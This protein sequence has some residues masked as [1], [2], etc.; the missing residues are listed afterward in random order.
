MY[1]KRNSILTDFKFCTM[2][3]FNIATVE[4]HDNGK[5]PFPREILA[6]EEL[7]GVITLSVPHVEISSQPLFLFFTVDITGSMS[8]PG[9]RG[10][11]KKIDYVIQT[12]KNMFTYLFKLSISVR[13]CVNTFNESVNVLIP[14]TELSDPGVLAELLR[15]VENIE[16]SGST[17]IEVALKRGR[18]L[19]VSYAE[20][21]RDHQLCHLFMT[22][23]EA[24]DGDRNPERLSSLVDPQF[25]MICVG[26][27]LKH[28]VE[29]LR[30]LGSHPNAEYQF[31]DNMENTTLVYGESIHQF[32]YPALRSIKIEIHGG[33]IYHW[34]TDTWVDALEE[35]LF[36]GETTKK[37]H[38]RCI[39]P[40]HLR[41]SISA[42]QVSSGELRTIELAVGEIDGIDLTRYM[43]RQRVQEILAS[44]QTDDNVVR[45]LVSKKEIRLVFRSLREYMREKE[46]TQDPFLKTLCDDLFVMY[47]TMDQKYGL[48]YSV[49]RQ[50]SQGRQQTYNIS[51]PT[52][53]DFSAAPTFSR[54]MLR[55]TQTGPQYA[56]TE[57]IDNMEAF[58]K[59]TNDVNLSL[60][61]PDTL[62]DLE[63]TLLEIS[64]KKPFLKSEDDIE[65]YNTNSAEKFTCYATPSIVNTVKSMETSL[66]T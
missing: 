29:L 22:D 8:E 37:Y 43:Y 7:F 34:K 60:I 42:V 21:Y 46:M 6:L 12:L 1:R 57:Y 65:N 26:Y 16:T 36:A 50:T 13:V 40:Q 28:N 27:G 3:F 9:A 30:K 47:S 48:M 4:V 20:D 55:R 38:L 19:L 14:P 10:G 62:D 45:S 35:N 53:F 61:H 44:S 32:L 2:S 49:A 24:T 63:A 66:S 31:V 18:E 23:G 17:N 56:P 5:F 15:T 64:K 41:V 25:P 58:L 33:K 59:E 54:P 51:T 11:S 39:D 52:P